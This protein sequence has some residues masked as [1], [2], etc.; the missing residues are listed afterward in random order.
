MELCIQ[1][2]TLKVECNIEIWQ[3]TNKSDKSKKKGEKITVTGT[4]WRN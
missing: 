4:D 3:H 2:W 1:P